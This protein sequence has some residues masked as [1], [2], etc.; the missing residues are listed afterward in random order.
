MLAVFSGT[1]YLISGAFSGSAPV[2]ACVPNSCG[3]PHATQH[4]YTAGLPNPC[5][6]LSNTGVAEALGANVE[7][8]TAH[9]EYHGCIW[10]GLP[11]TNRFGQQTVELDVGWLSRAEFEKF[12]SWEIVPGRTPFSSEVVRK[13]RIYGVGQVAFSP[14]NDGSALDVWYH[15]MVL[16]FSTTYLASPLANEKTLAKA[17]IAWL[18]QF[19]S[20]TSAR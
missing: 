10:S 11:F 13:A 20:E 2:V 14:Q 17:V 18:K 9:P 6:M 3:A 5:R 15:G 1:G 4:S 19:R 7:Y 8:K 16:S 12:Y